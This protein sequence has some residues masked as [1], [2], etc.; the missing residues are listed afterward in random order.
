MFIYKIAFGY[1][2][3]YQ[4]MENKLQQKMTYNVTRKA[5]CTCSKDILLSKKMYLSKGYF[6]LEVT[7]VYLNVLSCLKDYF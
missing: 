7:R 3:K 6:S 5:E 2:N 4:V 1:G